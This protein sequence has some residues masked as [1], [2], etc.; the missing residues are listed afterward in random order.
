MAK[1]IGSKGFDQVNLIIPQGT[2]L[3]FTVVQKDDEGNVVDL[4]G[5]TPHM[6][7]KTKS[8][9]IVANLDDCCTCT[10]ECVMVFIPATRTRGLPLGNL[11]WDLMI[12]KSETNVERFAYGTVQIVD[13][14]SMDGE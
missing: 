1:T 8:D 2:S 3:P 11:L 9:A 14:Y 7:F 12:E 13:T 5:F 4:S 10:S 6:V